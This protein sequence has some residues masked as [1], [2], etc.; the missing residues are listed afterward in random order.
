M[1]LLYKEISQNEYAVVRKML[2]NDI[3]TSEEFLWTLDNKPRTRTG[4]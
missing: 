4:A 1:E 2:L 3:E